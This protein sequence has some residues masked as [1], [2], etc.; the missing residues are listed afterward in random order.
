[1]AIKQYVEIITDFQ[2][3]HNWSECP[4][5][6]VSYLRYPHRHKVIVTVKIQTNEDRQI[7]FFMLKEKVDEII[8]TLFGDNRTKR[9]G[10]MSMEK[11]GFNLLN[12]LKNE[13]SENNI[14]IK[15]SEDGQV[16]GVIEYEFQER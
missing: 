2:A 1:M 9:L 5:D 4:F 16:S 14:T 8:N 12:E 11:I 13:Y 7:E 15:V 6:A 10:T 3:I